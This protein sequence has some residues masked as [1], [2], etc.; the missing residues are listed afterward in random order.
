MRILAALKRKKMDKP[1]LLPLKG[2]MQHYA[3]G[4]Y[5]FIPT[6]LG[7]QPEVGKP[8]AELWM[9][10]HHRG[11]AMVVT[12]EGEAPLDQ[13]FSAHPEALGKK[14]QQ[15][16][17]AQLP[18]L[19]KVLDVREMLSIQTHPTKAQAEAG[20][21]RENEAEIPLDAPHRNFKDNNHKP[22]VMVALTEFWLLH[23]F[24][25]LAEIAQILETTSAFAPL[26]ALF[27]DRDIQALYRQLMQM[28]QS[29]VDA[30]LGPL[31]RQLEAAPPEHKGAPGYWALQALN[32]AGG[33]AYDRG[34]FSIY[35]F[36]LVRLQPGQG[37]FQAAGIPHAYLEG[38]NVELMANSDNV[39]RGGLTPKHVDVEQLMKHIALAP[40]HPVSLDGEAVAEYERAYPVP[41]PD[42]QLNRSMLPASATYRHSP[43]SAEII[44]LL[45]G[46]IKVGAQVY[47]SGSVLMASA[48]Q[49][50]HF[51]AQE[52][53]VLFKAFVP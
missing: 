35:L 49:S 44:L 41:V 15:Q 52:R 23:G 29:K 13:W 48:G 51:Q 20:F 32:K 38:V 43:D 47:G 18:F 27:A 4:G 28:P 46:Q 34:V 12:E 8:V 31:H 37:I 53:S 24:R 16:F 11:K 14:V 6:L 7:M 42:F 30:I 33:K 19:F 40:V 10:T 1:V 3:W 45:E 50:Y 36:N 17:G 22:E 9:G 26:R 25:P 5:H 39:F 21:A 2:A